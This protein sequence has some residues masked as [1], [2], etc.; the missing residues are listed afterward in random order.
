MYKYEMDPTKTVG[1][2]SGG[3]GGGVGGGC[4]GGCLGVGGGWMCVCVCVCGGGGG[5]G[6]TLYP[7]S[8]IHGA[9]LGPPGSCGPHKPCYQGNKI[10]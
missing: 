7:D 10:G 4:G 5:G 2:Q 6:Y 8:K 1:G 9:H 3:G